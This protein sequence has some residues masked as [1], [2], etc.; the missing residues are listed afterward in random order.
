MGAPDVLSRL[1]AFG[2]RLM[3]EGDAIRAAAGKNGC[4]LQKTDTRKL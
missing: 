4:P 3:R 1:S 2:V